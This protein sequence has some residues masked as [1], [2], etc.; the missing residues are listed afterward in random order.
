MGRLFVSCAITCLA[1]GSALAASPLVV[2]H[3]V[4]VQPIAVCTTNGSSC[5]QVNDGLAQIG[6][7][8][9][10]LSPNDDTTDEIISKE[11]VDNQ[12]N[13]TRVTFLPLAQFNSPVQTLYTTTF[14]TLHF[15]KNPDCNTLSSSDFQQLVQQDCTAKTGCIQKV[16]NGIVP[17]PTT[18]GPTKACK[19]ANGVLQPTCVPISTTVTTL[20]M[21]FVTNMQL[22]TG[23]SGSIAGYGQINGNGIAINS[24]VVFGQ[25]LLDVMA[26][27]IA[28][29]LSLTHVTTTTTDLMTPGSTRV[30]PTT[31]NYPLSTSGLGTLFDSLSSTQVASVLDP[32]G[33]L[34]QILEVTASIKADAVANTFDFTV[35]IP[36][37]NTGASTSVVS[38]IWEVP[39]PF[40]FSN[41][42]FTVTNNPD[43]LNVAGSIFNGN[44][45]NNGSTILCGS[46]SLKCFRIDIT[47]PPKFGPG[48]T[49]SFSLAISNSNK[50]TQL[51]DLNGSTF[52]FL[53]D[54]GFATTSTFASSK[55]G[56]TLS[57]DSLMPAFN[58][59]SFIN[60]PDTFQP[61]TQTPCT[62][63][64]AGNCPNTQ[65]TGPPG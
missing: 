47:P 12:G 52:T 38:L 50:N 32:S 45:G 37:K 41:P 14:Q 3:Y 44:L 8:D 30:I 58:I 33:F 35:S 40:G 21:F 22:P 2:S 28:H 16:T 43:G 53:T 61:A 5:A 60:N 64:N 11:L 17:N 26:H 1:S 51:S 19:T 57:A 59:A 62:L 10:K 39:P 36:G 23:C 6:F 29:N 7:L 65:E 42:S 24:G 27:E 18:P 34:N 49:L 4:T 31:L 15:A 9:N 25:Q 46:S 48:D 54:D 20:N 63:S 56:T 13:A 55:S